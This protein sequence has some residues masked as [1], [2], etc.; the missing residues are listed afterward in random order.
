MDTRVSAGEA[1]RELGTSVPRVVRA[2]ERLGLDVDR[3]AGGRVGLTRGHLARLRRELG[4]APRLPGLSRTET[5]LIAALGRSPLGLASIRAVASRAGVSPTA[6]GVALHSLIDR[7]LVL[8]ERRVVAA[9]RAREVELFRPN[10]TAPEWPQL[11]PKL[12]RVS[13]PEPAPSPRP[14]QVPP[15]LRHLFWDTAPG[16]LDVA[17]HGDYIARRLLSAGDA[18]GLAWGAAHLAPGNWRHGQRTRG[19]GADRRVLAANLAEASRAAT[20]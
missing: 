19:L 11:A 6:A 8:R 14:R 15:R 9:G 18:E 13:P 2:I 7:G 5:K 1:A 4:S 12:G 10:V 3:G 20:A 16:Q 17:E